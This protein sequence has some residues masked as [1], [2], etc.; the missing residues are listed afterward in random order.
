L[1]YGALYIAG[2]LLMMREPVHGSIIITIFLLAAVSVSGILRI[3]IAL[4]HREIKRW[5]L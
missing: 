4:R 1:L 2:G 5:W 3:V